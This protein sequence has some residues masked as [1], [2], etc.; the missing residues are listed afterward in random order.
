MN[1]QTVTVWTRPAQVQTRQNPSTEKEEWTQSSIPNKDLFAIDTFS[2]REYQFS[3]MGCHYVYHQHSRAGH[4]SS[5][6]RPTQNGLHVIFVCLLFC[7][8]FFF[9]FLFIFCLRERTQS[10][11]DRKVG[12]IWKE[13]GERKYDQNIL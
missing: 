8:N 6:S 4:V 3:T 10:C 11:V 12:K 7:F 9:S 1:S 13:L 5:Y 2:K